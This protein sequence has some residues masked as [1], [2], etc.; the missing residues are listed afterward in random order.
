M[1]Q[2]TRDAIADAATLNLNCESERY[3][4]PHLARIPAALTDA[5]NNG[6]RAASWMGTV[7][8]DGAADAAVRA[9]RAAFRAVPELRYVE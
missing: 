3:R 6:A 5:M 2:G 4:W 9:A 8:E 1:T 7:N